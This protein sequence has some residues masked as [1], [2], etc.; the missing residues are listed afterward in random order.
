MC[1]YVYTSLTAQL[2]TKWVTVSWS[3]YNGYIIDNSGAE[4]V[5]NWAAR[6]CTCISICMYMCICVNMYLYVYIYIYIYLSV[7]V[8]INILYIHICIYV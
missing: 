4:Y 5:G 8:Y 3:L 2:P 6:V 1:I 7:N